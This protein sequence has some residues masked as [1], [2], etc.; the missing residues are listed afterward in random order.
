MKYYAFEPTF[1]M[2]VFTGYPNNRTFKMSVH[3]KL[4]VFSKRKDRNDWVLQK[5]KRICASRY[6]AHKILAGLDYHQFDALANEIID[7]EVHN[8]Q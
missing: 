8:E 7:K 5:R 6:E 2:D 4:A 3:G 1:G